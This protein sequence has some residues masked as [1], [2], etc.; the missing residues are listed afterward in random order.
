MHSLL[1]NQIFSLISKGF[2]LSPSREIIRSMTSSVAC[3]G[4]VLK[5]PWL[6]VEFLPPEVFVVSS[7]V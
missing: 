1:R 2:C 3:F 5:P 7:L 6:V 4:N